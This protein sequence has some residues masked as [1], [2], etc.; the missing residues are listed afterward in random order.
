MF[1]LIFLYN[2]IY[3]LLIFA[4]VG[5]MLMESIEVFIDAFKGER[6]ED[7]KKFHREMFLWIKKQFSISANLPDMLFIF[8][9]CLVI[10]YDSMFIFDHQSIGPVFS[11]PGL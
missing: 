8:S 1:G 2:Q 9:A 10:Q 5:A 11:T 6:I 3:F 4:A 7:V